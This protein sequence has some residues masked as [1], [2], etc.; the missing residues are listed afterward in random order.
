MRKVKLFFL[1]IA[2]LA[3][4]Q[5]AWADTKTFNSFSEG[6]NT[7]NPVTVYCGEVQSS[8]AILK[9]GKDIT[10]TVST[11]YEIKSMLF[12]CEAVNKQAISATPGG[13]MDAYPTYSSYAN[14][15]NS[16][17]FTMSTTGQYRITYIEV[18]YA[19]NTYKV[20]FN[21]NG[22]T[23]GSMS[24]QNFTYGTAQ[25]LT[26]NG[27]SKTGHTFAGWATS[28]TGAKVYNNQQSVNNLTATNGATV[29]LFAKWT[30]NTYKVKF[31]GNGSTS[32]S[33]SDQNFTY[34]TAQNLTANGFS[35]TGHTF[36]G[37]AT[38]T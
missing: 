10:I 9:S 21:G 6:N 17:S 15:I 34:G 22:N 16:S 23:G 36:A 31:N 4:A 3:I 14:N 8:K 32:G 18:N 5:G 20:K 2:L 33:M 35:N 37:W 13:L 26:A 24:N 29:N 11:G 28:S 30:A 19:A 1:L 7:N 27:F 25:N 12:N 38:S